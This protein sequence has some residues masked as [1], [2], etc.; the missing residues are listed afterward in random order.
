MEE[1]VRNEVEE[2]IE[3]VLAAAQSIPPRTTLS[4]YLL[5]CQ[6]AV[7]RRHFTPD[8]DERLRLVFAGYLRSRAI[9]LECIELLHPYIREKNEWHS[10]ILPFTTAFAAAAMLNRA[11]AYILEISKSSSIIWKK[12]D[13]AEIR[14][15]IEG[16]SLTEL[17]KNISSTKNMWRFYNATQFFNIHKDAIYEHLELSNHLE[18]ARC[19]REEEPTLAVSKSLYLKRK[20]SYRVYDFMRLNRSGYKK[21]MF[22][23]FRYAG[24][25]IADM[26]QPFRRT[27]HDQKQVTPD[28]L[29]EIRQH[30]QAGDII[31][32]RHNDALSNLFLPGFWPHAAFVYDNDGRMIESKKDGVKLRLIEETLF[33]DS[34]LVLRPKLN[35]G[36]IEQVCKNARS[37]VGKRYDFLFDFV[38]ADR[39]ACTEL[40]YRAFHSIDGISLELQDHSGRKCLSAEDLINQAVGSGKFEVSAIFGTKQ[41]PHILYGEE[42]KEVLRT[43]YSSTW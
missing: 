1:T 8:E 43:S 41:S 18:L 12:L 9:L 24:C 6:N 39:L 38:Q 29:L 20:L 14:F 16:N 37:H 34:F 11:T 25:R 3:Q 15:G 2:L 26:R 4:E 31:I 32:T 35:E 22:H 27:P 30:I 10:N 13:E 28:I 21:A 5:D 19:L 17:Y 7:A 33:V 23:L 42:A 36:D 40:V